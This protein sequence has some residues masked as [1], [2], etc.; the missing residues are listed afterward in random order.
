ML[1]VFLILLLI[2]ILYSFIGIFISGGVIKDREEQNTVVEKIENKNKKVKKVTRHVFKYIT[3]TGET[4]SEYIFYDENGKRLAV[5]SKKE[6]DFDKV[7][8]ILNEKYPNLADQ[9][10]KVGY[11]KKNPAYIIEKGHELLVL[12]FETLKEVFYMKEGK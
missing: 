4:T 3:Y 11:G 6:T 10:I 8:S 9:K 7:K 2:G 1:T 5:R 12:D